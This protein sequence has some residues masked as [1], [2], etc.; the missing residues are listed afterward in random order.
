MY[1]TQSINKVILLRTSQLS[2]DSV[3]SEIAAARRS[4][5]LVNMR[6]LSLQLCN[7]ADALTTYG[8]NIS[9]LGVLRSSGPAAAQ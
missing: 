2:L 6:K 9:Q 1:D 4:S 5:F 8:W 3:P 7:A